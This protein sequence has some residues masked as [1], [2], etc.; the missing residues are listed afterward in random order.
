[1]GKYISGYATLKVHFNDVYVEDGESPLDAVMNDCE[2]L[3][4]DWDIKDEYGD[5]EFEEMTEGLEAD[6]EV[7]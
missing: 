6:S 7:D 1:M 5:E 3:D 4:E 2:V